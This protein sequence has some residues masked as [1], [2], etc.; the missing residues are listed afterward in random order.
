LGLLERIRAVRGTS[1]EVEQRFA[2]D[3]WFSNYLFPNQFSYNGSVYPIGLNGLNQTLAGNR[4]TE[5]SQT[6][7]GY[8]AA[9]QRCPPAFAA[10]MVRAL[11]LSQVRFTFRNLPWATPAT[12]G[13][14]KAAP[15]RLFSTQALQLLER[16]WPNATTGELVTRMEWH[17]GLGGAAF[18]ALRPGR[19]QVLR[20]DWTGI[21]HGS[22]SQEDNPGGALDGELLGYWYCNGGFDNPWGYKPEF[23]LPDECIHWAPLPN[24]TG[25]SI[26]M[27]WLTP[28]I[29]EIQGDRLASEFKIRYFE[30]G[31]TPNLVISGLP[32]VTKPQFDQMVEMMEEKHAGAANAFRTLYL[33][34]GA[35]AKVIGNSLQ[36]TDFRAV[37]AAGETRISFLSRVPAS[38]LGI[39]EGMQGSSLNAGN[40]SAARRTFADTWVYPTLEDLAKSLAPL[41]KVPS[42]AELWFDVADIPLLREDAKDAAEIEQIKAATIEMH[43][44]SGFTPESAVAAVTGQNHQL[45]KHTGLQSIQMVA[46]APESGLAQVLQTKAQTAAEL[47]KAGFEPD[48]VIEAVDGYDLSK[49]VSGELV[50][51]QLIEDPTVAGAEPGVQT[52][53]SG[54]G[55][56]PAPTPAPATP[57]GK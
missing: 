13:N 52:I 23:L 42:D 12:T 4:A 31:A 8:T 17:A 35:D 11:V 55:S 56:S 50:P 19:L 28:A 43:I 49:L 27:S 22:K 54:P 47:V 25:E 37:T 1:T 18:V 26:G 33:T 32:A 3:D 6:L 9:L 15:R 10:E 14:P 57:K 16:P 45:L 38:L 7:P 48:S 53:P 2:A 5:I 20:P 44:R 34:A 30:Q 41:I 51:R 21:V 46:P 24:P 39:S 36:E 29:R 40:F